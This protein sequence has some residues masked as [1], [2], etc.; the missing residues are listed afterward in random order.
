MQ[1]RCILK[2]F[3]RTG[4]CMAIGACTRAL[5]SVYAE[6]CNISI[7]A[8]ILQARRCTHADHLASCRWSHAAQQPVE[9]CQARQKYHVA[10]QEGGHAPVGIDQCQAHRRQPRRHMVDAARDGLHAQFC[11]LSRVWGRQ[12]CR[13]A[14]LSNATRP[15]ACMCWQGLRSGPRTWMASMSSLKDPARACSP[16]AMSCSPPA[17]SVRPCMSYRTSTACVR[18]AHF[19]PCW[20]QY[21]ASSRAL[22]VWRSEAWQ[23]RD[24][25]SPNQPRPWR[26]SRQTW[27]ACPC[28]WSG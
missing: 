21:C 6:N 11:A 16:P 27:T 8:F 13:Q 14:P 22:A 17:I 26:R 2:T 7:P 10:Q 19:P 24:S 15:A 3:W 25:R 20:L 5:T 9:E 1:V 28:R 12:G 18:Q 23:L 4:R